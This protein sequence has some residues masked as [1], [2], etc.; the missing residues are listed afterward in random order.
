MNLFNDWNGHLSMILDLN[1]SEKEG[2]HHYY[3]QAIEREVKE[4]PRKLHTP[5]GFVCPEGLVSGF[6]FLKKHI[7]SGKSLKPFLSKGVDRPRSIDPLLS[8]WNVRHFHLGGEIE[9]GFVKR[10][11]ALAFA[12]ITSDDVYI[13]CIANHGD[14][15]NK[16]II[17]RAHDNWPFLLKENLLTY[18]VGINATGS[19]SEIDQSRS[20]AASTYVK[21]DDGTEYLFGDM[22]ISGHNYFTITAS[23]HMMR[24]F[25]RIEARINEKIASK[26]IFST[27][28]PKLFFRDG[29][30]IV[31]CNQTGLSFDITDEFTHELNRAIALIQGREA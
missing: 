29:R 5:K 20:N 10:T 19:Q 11:G 23:G 14:W 21:V 30:W 7:E 12:K 17:Q 22:S 28:Q 9:N 31:E 26:K 15:S 2:A 1:E 6:N 4:K 18:M 24:F 25:A 3:F 8:Q 16:D 27:S 13:L